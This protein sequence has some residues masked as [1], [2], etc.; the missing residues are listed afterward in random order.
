MLVTSKEMLEQA[1]HDGFAIPSPDYVDCNSIRAFVQVAEELE[2]PI[3]LSF[4]EVHMEHLSVEEAALLGKF[5]AE[6]AKTPV[7]LHLDHGVHLDV[8]KKAIDLGFTS[9]MIDAS[10]EELDENIR[11]TKEVVDLAHARGVVVEALERVFEEHPGNWL[12][13]LA[14]GDAAMKDVL[15]HY[16]HVLRCV[17]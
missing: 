10:S 13:L 1:R 9:V 14:T 2:A 5:Y 8:I 3:I 12:D 4:A 17:K 11:R 15:R 6:R 16:Y 7:A